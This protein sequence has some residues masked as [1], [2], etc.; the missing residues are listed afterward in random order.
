MLKKAKTNSIRRNF[1]V[2][3][4]NAIVERGFGDCLSEAYRWL[5]LLMFAHNNF[6]SFKSLLEQL[7][8]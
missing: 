4:K 3:K 6:D 2:A 7:F 8:K 5:K 1:R